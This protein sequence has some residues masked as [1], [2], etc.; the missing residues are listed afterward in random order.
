MARRL[1]IFLTHPPAARANYYGTRALEALRQAG[2]VAFNPE[3][4]PLATEALIGAARDCD[5]IV[6]DRQTPG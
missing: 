5:F 1:R 6:A 3:P 4:E 2:E